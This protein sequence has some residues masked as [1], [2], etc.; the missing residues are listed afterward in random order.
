MARGQKMEGVWGRKFFVRLPKQSGRILEKRKSP[1]V[2]LTFGLLVWV[3]VKEGGLFSSRFRKD[4]NGH[5]ALPESR[6]PS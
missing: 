3:F 2:I 5:T 4:S 1:L 6:S